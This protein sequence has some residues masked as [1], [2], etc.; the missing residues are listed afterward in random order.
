MELTS[1]RLGLPLDSIVDVLD[2]SGR[3]L[4]SND[5]SDGQ[6]DSRLE[7]RV[8][9]DG[10]FVARVR[11]VTG[12]GGPR[13][14]YR[15]AIRPPRPDFSLTVT[16]DNPRVT[17]GGTAGLQVTAQRLDGFQGDIVLAVPNPPPGTAISQA[18]LTRNQMQATLT[19][20]VPA[21]AQPGVV[22]LV[23]DG[24]ATIDDRKV[25][26]TATAAESIR[27][28]DR[29]RQIP[30][31]ELVLGVLPAGPFTLAWSRP[32]LHVA[33]GGTA[34]F[35]VRARRAAGFTGPI[36]LVLPGLPP[37]VTAPP[38]TIEQGKDE[39]KLAITA[40]PRAAVGTYRITANGT[41]TAGPQSFVQAVP[42]LTVNV[43][44][45]TG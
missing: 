16:D 7:F 20:T 25:T 26:H 11:D 44:P 35:A 43:T 21:A 18:T 40:A 23:V 1:R 24:T 5:D 19:I 28:V 36:R 42:A 3:V 31:N 39:A 33:A 27:N 15:L 2:E 29:I 34:E 41:A 45:P 22:P 32:E 38:V 37:Q 10:T 30:V 14:V 12:Y 17:A 6:S 13:Y 4:Q 8:P 9:R